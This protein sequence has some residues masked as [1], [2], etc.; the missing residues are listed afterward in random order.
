MLR[1]KMPEAEV[2][3]WSK[4]QKKQ[5]LGYKFHRQYSIINF[6]VDFYCPKLKL[7]IEVDGKSHLTK[8]AKE[9]DILRQENIE[10]ANIEFLR[11]TN[12]EVYKDLKYVI[13]EIRNKII[14][15]QHL[16]TTYGLVESSL[17]LPPLLSRLIR[18]LINGTSDS[19]ERG[20]SSGLGVYNN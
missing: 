17:T 16:S 12:E 7:A 5:Q 10:L 13:R 6:V 11:F 19:S 14:A 18:P 9:Y 1:S 3:L 4:L 15:L 8:S 20:K 2:I